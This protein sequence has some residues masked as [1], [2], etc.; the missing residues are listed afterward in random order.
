MESPGTAQRRPCPGCG[1]NNRLIAR[2]CGWCGTRLDPHPVAPL[3]AEARLGGERRYRVDQLLGQGGFGEVYLIEDTRLNRLCVAK[4]LAITASL[5]DTRM[6][7]AIAAFEHEARLLV[8]LSQPGHP[9]IP[10]IFEYLED[11]RCLVMKYVTGKDLWRLVKS[12]LDPLPEAEALRYVRDVCS[13]LAYMHSRTPQP[14]LHGDLKPQN[15]MLDEI[16]RVWLIDFGLARRVVA[17]HIR[18]DDGAPRLVG[19][20]PGYTPP[21]QWDGTAEPRSD[22]YA[23]G[24]TLYALL[25]GQ[26]PSPEPGPPQVAIRALNPDVR[27]QVEHVIARAMAVDVQARPSAA[28]LLAE[29]DELLASVDVPPPPA[30]VSPPLV[31]SFVGRAVELTELAQRLAARHIVA[32]TGMPGIGKTALAARLA[33]QAARPTHIFWHS[34]RPGESAETLIWQFAGWLAHRGRSWAWKQLQQAHQGIG[35][36]P[37]PELFAEHLSQLAAGQGYLLCLDDLHLVDERP[38]VGQVLERFVRAAGEGKLALILTSRTTVPA[39]ED[40]PSPLGG[41]SPADTAALFTQQDIQLGAGLLAALHAATEGNPEFLVLAAALVQRVPDPDTLIA[42]LPASAAIEQYLLQE[43]DAKLSED[44]QRAME[45]VAALLG[46]GGSRAAIEALAEGLSLRRALAALVRRNLLAVERR[47]DEPIYHQHAIVQ[48]F[49]Y[50]SPSLC[51]RQAMHARAGAFYA[52]DEHALVLAVRH[53]IL[54]DDHPRAAALIGANPWRLIQQG[55]ARAISALL[56]DLSLADV[57]AATRAEVHMAQAEAAALLGAFPQ[58][59]A[60]IEQAITEGGGGDPQGVVR[61]ARRFRLLAQVCEQTGDYDPAEQACHQGLALAAAPSGTRTESAR[62][63]A[64]LASVLMRRSAFAD[65]AA[66]CQ[67]GLAALPPEPEVPAE[68]SALLLRLATIEGQRD[69]YLPALEI[70]EQ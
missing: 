69:S 60:A 67:A 41:L 54:A 9:N 24:A 25:T 19:G 34:F 32:I 62:L 22:I 14:V 17:A 70:F 63:Y 57:G 5:S 38:Q 26:R 30:P 56:G 64:Q 23:L 59:R 65:A 16:G 21:E 6:Q 4:R 8:T 53:Y 12:R 15:I 10:E 11:D 7:Q 36:I 43:I 39:A 20:T 51:A 52:A 50:D 55:H 44:E 45:A 3:V 42:R 61:Q 47:G 66:A 49:Y 58:S 37:S 18:G 68:R 33:Q 13:A 28:M 1:F 46:Y 48:R 40:A 27:P 2:C 35:Q 29:L 31:T